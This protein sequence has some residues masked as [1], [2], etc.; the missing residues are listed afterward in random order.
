MIFRYFRG[1]K[2]VKDVAFI[3]TASRHDGYPAVS[4]SLQF[5]QEMDA[6]V[7]I[8]LLSGGQYSVKSQFYQLLQCLF[9]ALAVVEGTVESNAHPLGKG[10]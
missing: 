4:L 6:S 5:P 3:D 9:G 1:L 8:G 2:D 10:Q 7:C